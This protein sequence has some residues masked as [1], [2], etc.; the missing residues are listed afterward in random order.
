MQT[1]TIRPGVTAEFTITEV[2]E[3]L[4]WGVEQFGKQVGLMVLV[5]GGF[6]VR[7]SDMQPVAGAGQIYA[8]KEEAVAKLIDRIGT[9]EFS[10]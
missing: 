3:G 5:A 2:S 6:V 7:Q 9:M 4:V 1:V 8:T 10:I